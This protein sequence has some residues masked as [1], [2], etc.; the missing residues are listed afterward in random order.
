MAEDLSAAAAAGAADPQAVVD[1]I[2]G[3]TNAAK[4]WGNFVGNEIFNKAELATKI[5]E[6]KAKRESLMKY[7]STDGQ[8]AM[9]ALNQAIWDITVCIKSIQSLAIQ[10]KKGA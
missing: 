7:A 1:T 5:G 4:F 10:L 9:V 8:Q 2:D 6:L 3:L